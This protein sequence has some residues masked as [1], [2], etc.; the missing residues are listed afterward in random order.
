MRNMSFSMTEDALLAGE[1]TVTRRLGWQFLK[2]GDRVRAV[3]KGMGLKKGE[4]V[5]HLAVIKVVDVQRERLDSI[6]LYD[7][8]LEGFNVLT[9]GF[10]DPQ[11]DFIQRFCKAMKCRPE[12]KVTRIEFRVLKFR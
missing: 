6:T 11:L 7:V 8:Y 9:A 10:G 1:K 4:K 12:Q 3:R 5:K 2:P